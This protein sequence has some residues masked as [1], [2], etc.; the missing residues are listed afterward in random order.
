MTREERITVTAVGSTDAAAR[1]KAKAREAGLRVVT[2]SKISTT[3]HDLMHE[4]LP[5]VWD[6]T[7]A[8]KDPVR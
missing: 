8:V 5:C 6:V 2:V 3:Q 7:L 4:G 1:A